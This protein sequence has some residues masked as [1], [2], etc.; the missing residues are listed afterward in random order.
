MRRSRASARRSRRSRPRCAGWSGG[1]AQAPD[2]IDPPSKALDAALTA[3]DEARTHLDAALRAANHDPHELER[4][5]ERLFALR[6]AARK[7][8]VPVDN[9]AALNA[10]H[11]AD[12][13][14]LDAGA[15]ELKKLEAAAREA[16]AAYTQGRR[17][18]LGRA[19]EGR[20]QARQG[21]DGAN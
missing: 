11:A 13:A 15:A 9:L 14:A 18:A 4:I 7:Y 6:A 20:R 10:K 1:A 17:R 16:E 5:E 12:L 3:L 21:R 8:N 19:Q 2:L